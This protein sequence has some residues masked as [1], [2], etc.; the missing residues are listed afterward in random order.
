MSYD[1]VPV[2]ESSDWDQTEIDNFDDSRSISP[3]TPASFKPLSPSE[4]KPDSLSPAEH[5]SSKFEVVY[6]L[7][8]VI[9]GSGVLSLPYALSQSGWTGLLLVLFVAFINSYTGKLVIKCLRLPSGTFIKSYSDI[10]YAAFGGP[11]RLIV[12]IFTYLMM[13]GVVS[14]YLILSGMNCSQVFGG[15]RRIWIVVCGGIVLVPYLA[16]KSLKE[17]AVLRYG[18]S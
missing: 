13:L 6:H 9:A 12:D 1:Q 14:V 4:F 15:E 3:S 10:G 11:G 8:C 18:N 7:V 5:H 17:V 2:R 16:F